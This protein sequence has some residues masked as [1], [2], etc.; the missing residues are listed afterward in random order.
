M[1]VEVGSHTCCTVG[2]WIGHWSWLGCSRKQIVS[3]HHV[4]SIWHSPH[5]LWNSV[6]NWPSDA[7][8]ASPHCCGHHNPNCCKPSLLWYTSLW[9]NTIV[10]ACH[11]DYIWSSILRIST[12][13]SAII[14][15]VQK[16]LIRRGPT[17][18]TGFNLSRI[19]WSPPGGA[20]ARNQQLCSKT[21]T[22]IWN[23]MS[24]NPSPRPPPNLFFTKN[25]RLHD[26]Q[27]C[28]TRDDRSNGLGRLKTP[29]DKHAFNLLPSQTCEHSKNCR[30]VS[31]H[32]NEHL[33][34]NRRQ[35]PVMHVPYP[36]R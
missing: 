22:W 16:R 17:L 3:P 1:R 9:Y 12:L 18:Q 20:A 36:K 31:Q 34:N 13:M 29:I 24:Y 10:R 6:L 5:S 33:F 30:R 25:N 23:W 8:L 4:S 2:G 11:K 7:I 32:S 35:L 19:T 26:P 28:K 27:E 15:Y 14:H 21:G